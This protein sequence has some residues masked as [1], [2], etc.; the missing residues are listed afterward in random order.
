MD[1]FI[2]MQKKILSLVQLVLQVV[3]EVIKQRPRPVSK[4]SCCQSPMIIIIG[5][6]QPAW[7]SG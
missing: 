5:F 2:V 3:I 7:E 1:F 4:C 6:R